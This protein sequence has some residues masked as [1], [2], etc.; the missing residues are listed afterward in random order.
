MPKDETQFAVALSEGRP[1]VTVL[2]AGVTADVVF[3]ATAA[4]TESVRNGELNLNVGF[5]Q[6]RVKAAGDMKQLME[7][8]RSVSV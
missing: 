1:V 6:G 8:L 4:I 7:L 2:E 3:T 5:M